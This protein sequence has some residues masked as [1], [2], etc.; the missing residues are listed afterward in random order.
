MIIGLLF[1]SSSAFAQWTQPTPGTGPIWYSSGTVGIG[2]SAAAGDKLT[3]QGGALSFNNPNNPYPY[4]GLDY[5]PTSDALRW[6]ANLGSTSLTNTWLVMKR[7]SGNLGVGTS[8]PADKITIQGGA[9]S[10]NN[11]NN[12]VPYVGFDYDVTE[13]ALRLR[14]NLGVLVLNATAMSVKRSTGVV[15][16]AEPGS[17]GT[18]LTVNGNVSVTGS[19]TGAS[20]IGATYQDVAEWV[21]ASGD[22]PAGTVVVLN[23]EKENAVIPSSHAYDPAVAGVVSSNPGVIL[24]Q[25]GTSKAKI[26]TTGRVKVRV[27]ASKHPIHIGDLLVTSETSGAAMVSEPLEIGGVKIHRPGTLIGK[28]L[29]P[30]ASGEG[31]ILVLLSL[32]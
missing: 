11:P 6:R 1:A 31:Q 25:E 23:R 32:Q 5:D 9:L 29:E 2:T 27:N 8:N 10:F 15:T 7:D 14:T 4:V 12:P 21:P 17:S 19:I 28:A 22:V 26:A 24:G 18:K 13:D 16:I 3:I 30:L 20:V